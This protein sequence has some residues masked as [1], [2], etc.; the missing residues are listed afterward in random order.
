MQC[1]EGK[2]SPVKGREGKGRGRG[3]RDL[4]NPNILAWRPI[5]PALVVLELNLLLTLT[6]TKLSLP[7]E[8]MNA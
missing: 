5:C 2:D 4:A 8:R 6:M 1:S 7:I 3:G